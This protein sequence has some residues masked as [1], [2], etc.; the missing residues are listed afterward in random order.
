MRTNRTVGII[1]A[2]FYFAFAA[3]YIFFTIS[4]NYRLVCPQ[5]VVILKIAG[6]ILLGLMLLTM[7]FIQNKDLK[8]KLFGFWMLPSLCLAVSLGASVFTVPA[9]K[10]TNIMSCLL[11]LGLGVLALCIALAKNFSPRELI[12][13]LWFLPGFLTVILG[14]VL[15][16]NGVRDFGI[17][18]FVL[19]IDTLLLSGGLLLSGKCMNLY[20]CENYEAKIKPQEED[21]FDD[22]EFFDGE[23]YYENEAVEEC[24]EW[25]ENL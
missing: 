23:Y 8:K 9:G 19:Y 16:L 4:D 21:D 2:I 10:V 7:A 18:Q 11:V 1:G 25:E 12:V 13:N 14:I 17:S 5:W 22:E 24:E 20:V 3:I 6:S 15:F